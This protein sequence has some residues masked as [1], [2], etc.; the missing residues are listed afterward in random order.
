MAQNPEFNTIKIGDSTNN[1]TLSSTANGLDIGGDKITN[2]AA[3]TADT[4]AVN[5]SQL[6]ASQAA[7]TSKVAAGSGI[8]VATTTNT[9]GSSTYTVAAKTDGNTIKVDD[10]G[11]IAAVTSGITS[12][13][14]GVATATTPTAL[15]TAGDVAT[16]INNSGFTLT[17]SGANGSLVKP[18]STIN[19]KNTDGNI[20]IS[21]EASNNEVVYNLSKNISLDSVTTGNT[22]MNTTG[23]TIANADPTKTV[24]LTSTGLNNGG[25]KITNIAAGTA[26]TDAVNVSQLKA[27]Q[28]ASTNKVAAGSGIT[29]ATTTNTDGSSTYTVAAKTDGKT[30]KVDDAG[31]IA[32]VTSGITSST[33][34]IATA[35]T[36]TALATA[37]DVATAINNSGFTLSTS[38]D[39]GQKLSGN[40]ELI[41]SG[42]KVTI[43][44]GKNLTVKQ[45]SNGK[46]TLAT[47]D[48][49]SVNTVSA[50]QVNVAIPAS[51]IVVSVLPM[52]LA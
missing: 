1:T 31:N 24:S 40:D 9:D 50:S 5:V 4:D 32:A 28:A 26:D 6:K 35:T 47:A 15:A 46:V 21:K 20:V 27:S 34:G 52:V 29:V 43:V 10:A 17:A 23:I 51:L 48:D 45:E 11:N 38:V 13:S 16:A 49:L 19:M 30:I 39:G 36:P 3:G 7:S 18:G 33:T 14:T 12:S 8:T 44:A 41:T 2:V 25:N 22:V 37:G 42:K